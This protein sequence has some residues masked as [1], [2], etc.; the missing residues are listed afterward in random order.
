MEDD[1]GIQLTCKNCGKSETIT[2]LSENKEFFVWS[3]VTTHE[4]ILTQ[5]YMLQCSNCWCGYNLH[6]DIWK[7]MPLKE[8]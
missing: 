3:T 7:H 5:S 1:T 6:V 4:E 2:T 8:E